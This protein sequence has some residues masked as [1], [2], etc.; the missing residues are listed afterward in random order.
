MNVVWLGL[1]K[2]S[3]RSPAPGAYE[4]SACVIDPRKEMLLNVVLLCLSFT[5]VLIDHAM[6]GN[7]LPERMKEGHI[8]VDA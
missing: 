2:E 6:S 8:S 1:K 7:P 4:Q 3:T 5:C